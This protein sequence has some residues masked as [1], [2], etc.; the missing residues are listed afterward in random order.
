MVNTQ[1]FKEPVLYLVTIEF[2]LG[3]SRGVNSNTRSPYKVK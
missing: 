3:A 2:V 1:G